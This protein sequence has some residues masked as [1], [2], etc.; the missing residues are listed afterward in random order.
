[1]L[2]DQVV[3]AFSFEPIFGEVLKP[4]V[5]WMVWQP[6][7]F[8]SMGE[9][10]CL[11]SA[12]KRLKSSCFVSII[13]MGVLFM[14]PRIVLRPIFWT[15]SSLLVCVLAAVAHALAPYSNVGLITPV[16]TVLII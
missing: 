8:V 12:L 3:Q 5:Q 14:A 1:M 16:Y 15:R 7:H 10:I 9:K 11:S 2:F 13:A 6:L 4:V